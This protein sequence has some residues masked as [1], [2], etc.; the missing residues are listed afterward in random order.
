MTLGNGTLVSQYIQI[1]KTVHVFFKFT[2]GSTSSMGSS[3]QFTLPVT[4]SSTFGVTDQ[5][6]GTVWVEDS[7]TASYF[8]WGQIISTTVIRM[9]IG[10]AAGTYLTNSGISSTVPMTWTTGDIIMITFTYEAA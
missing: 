6:I 8:G 7:G 1:G 2:L 4:A 10:N 9:V 5:R 3:P